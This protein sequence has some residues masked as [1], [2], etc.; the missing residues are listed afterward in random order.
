MFDIYRVTDYVKPP[1]IVGA[2]ILAAMVGVYSKIPA[3]GGTGMNFSVSEAF[4]KRMAAADPG[5]TLA[6]KRAIFWQAKQ[7]S[8]TSR[9]DASSGKRLSVVYEDGTEV[10]LADA[11]TGDA[12]Q[13][14]TVTD[15]P[16]REIR[17]MQ[18]DAQGHPQYYQITH[19]DEALLNVTVREYAANPG[20]EAFSLERRPPM[21]IETYPSPGGAAQTRNVPTLTDEF[22]AH[23][24]DEIEDVAYFKAL[25]AKS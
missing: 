19:Y 13:V 23:L 25:A 16:H 21:A 1:V 8:D 12:G 4:N 17:Q 14:L 11:Q 24:A 2:V 9:E 6:Q 20:Y 15:R 7:V 18:I 5:Q 3:S 22:A 10:L